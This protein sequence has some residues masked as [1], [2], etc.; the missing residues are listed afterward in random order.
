[1]HLIKKNIL[2]INS[3]NYVRNKTLNNFLKRKNN[4]IEFNYRGNFIVKNIKILKTFFFDFDII[5]INWNSWSSLF[6]VKFINIFKN[7]PII[8]D[9]YTLIYEDY[10]E[11][12][13]KKNTLLDFLYKNI[14]KFIYSNCKVLITDT[15]IH[16][17]KI[18]KLFKHKKILILNVLQK[19]LNLL[20]K[21]S[22]NSKIRLIH[23]G[24][25]RKL[26]GINKM[27]DLIYK[28]PSKLKKKIY[29]QIIC[30]DYFNNY[31]NQIIRLKCENYIKLIKPL[32]YKK[33]FKM[34]EDSDICMGVFGNTEKAESVISNF[35]VT[36]TNLGK[37]IIT[38]N[39][40]AA[41][42]YLNKNKGI[43]LLKKPDHLNFQ[44]F[45]KRYLSSTNFQKEIKL[46]SKDI[47]LKNF[48]IEENLKNFEKQLKIYF[49]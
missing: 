5:L 22:S 3:I 34:I 39:T 19:N 9:A 13:I 27:I 17:K 28:L 6:M 20:K 11:N 33:Y 7:K 12:K 45:I 47:F 14:E 49:N 36:S 8:Y 4:L 42:I 25:D 21:D 30:D 40:K 23:A 37:I 24:A 44:R 15:D 18:Q 35:I 41:R 16:K 26:H 46:K 43:F 1:M 38:K 2:V 29:F 48:E 10:S 31:R 32:S